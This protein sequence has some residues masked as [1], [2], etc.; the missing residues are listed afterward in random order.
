MNKQDTINRVMPYLGFYYYVYLLAYSFAKC[1]C[2]QPLS[3]L[4]K[5]MKALQ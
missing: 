2:S 5:M 4:V 3:Y 1:S